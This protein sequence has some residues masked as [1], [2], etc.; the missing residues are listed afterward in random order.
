VWDYVPATTGPV[1]LKV[2]D[3]SKADNTGTL[4]VRVLKAGASTAGYATS[5]PATPSVPQAPEEAD[6]DG[7][8]LYW[9]DEET[10]D[11]SATTGGRTEAVL[12]EDRR[13]RIR[14]EGTWSAGDGIEADGECTRTENGTWQRK[15]S[16]DPLHPDLDTFD[17][18]VD[19]QDLASNGCR[20]D[21]V[22][23]YDYYPERDGKA[24][25]ALWDTAAA[26]N[27]GSLKVTVRRIRG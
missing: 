18:Y 10:V 11:V 23:E 25:F 3:V 19:G 6:E 24:T 20:E 16:S 9:G 2:D 26:D 15:R 5:L 27:S 12:R 7:D 13:Y 17:L 1:T 14:V 22:Y 4:T 21:H 8:Y